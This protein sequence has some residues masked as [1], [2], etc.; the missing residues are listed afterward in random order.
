MRAD[1]CCEILGIV[2]TAP[3]STQSFQIR[4][5]YNHIVS[6]A[7]ILESQRRGVLSGEIVSSITKVNY[8]PIPM[9]KPRSAQSRPV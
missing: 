4:P 1:R 7:H 2:Y 8:P 9:V 3:K 6:S 5:V